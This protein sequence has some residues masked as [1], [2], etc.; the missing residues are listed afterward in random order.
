MQM[1]GSHQSE[2]R[3]IEQTLAKQRQKELEPRSLK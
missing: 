3:V 2:G 1:K